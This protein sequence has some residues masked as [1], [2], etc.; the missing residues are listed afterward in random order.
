MHDWTLKTVTVDWSAGSVTIELQ[1]AGMPKVLRAYEVAELRVPRRQA[2]G[3]SVS[4][5]ECDGPTA[6]DGLSR[7]SI[8]MQTGDVIEL[9]AARFAM[10]IN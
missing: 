4:V 7:V 6:H 2:W 8:E 5:N 9:I 3:P 10:P 1:T